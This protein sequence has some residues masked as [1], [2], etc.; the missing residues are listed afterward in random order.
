MINEGQLN[1]LKTRLAKIADLSGAA[2]VL[3]WDQETKMPEGGIQ[4]RADQMSTLGGL[5]H[6]FFVDEE[7]GDLLDQ[8]SEQAASADY[9]SDDVSLIRVKKRE[10]EKQVR[11]PTPLVMELLSVSAVATEASAP[12]NRKALMVSS[13]LAF[14]RP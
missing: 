14:C 9:A 1:Q 8:L 3:G 11:V 2:G 13:C 5:A 12:A 7:V 4:A 10:Y 6:Q